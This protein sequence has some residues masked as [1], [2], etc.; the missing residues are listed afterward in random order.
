[1]RARL[2]HSLHDVLFNRWTKGLAILG[3]GYEIAEHTGAISALKTMGAEHGIISPDMRT[4]T[5]GETPEGLAHRISSDIDTF[6]QSRVSDIGGHQSFLIKKDGDVYQLYAL[7]A[8]GKTPASDTPLFQSDSFLVDMTAA[9][10]ADPDH[11][12]AIMA[13]NPT[14]PAAQPFRNWFEQHLQSKQVSSV[15]PT[16]KVGPRLAGPGQ[17]PTGFG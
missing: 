9:A 17:G 10:V 2:G 14:A 16:D 11:R 7:K 12:L 8:D 3:I 6:G 5:A 4:P 13:K 1:L 15:T